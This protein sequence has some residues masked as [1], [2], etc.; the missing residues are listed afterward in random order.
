MTDLRNYDS[1]SVPAQSKE[2][3]K[4]EW[5]EGDSS[6]RTEP[7][8]WTYTTCEAPVQTI[9]YLAQDLGYK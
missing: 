1:V 6:N 7:C 9:S 5:H 2:Y 8:Q 4:K 3:I